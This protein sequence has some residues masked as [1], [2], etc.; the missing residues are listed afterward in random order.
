VVAQNKLACERP[1]CL[2]GTRKLRDIFVTGHPPPHEEG[3]GPRR[4]HAPVEAEI[5]RLIH[6]LRKF[7]NRF[8]DRAYTPV[9][10][11]R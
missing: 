6:T 2:R 7:V 4:R 11:E 1:P 3:N 9:I 5:I 8:Y 10:H